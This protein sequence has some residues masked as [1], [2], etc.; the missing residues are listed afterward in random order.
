MS[1]KLNKSTIYDI[2]KERKLKLNKTQLITRLN[3]AKTNFIRFT[4]NSNNK[5]GSEK[6]INPALWQMGH[7]IF[8]Y[9]NLVINNLRNCENI[10]GDIHPSITGIYRTSLNPTLDRQ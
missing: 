9:T 7:V 3:F 5:V 6:H 2:L 1:L 8:F 4:K 10:K